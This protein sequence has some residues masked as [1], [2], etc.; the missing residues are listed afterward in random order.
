MKILNYGSLNIDHVYQM[1]AFVKAGETLSA[2]DCQLHTGGKGLNQSVALARAGA[3]VFHGGK[4]GADGIELKE[5]LEKAGAD[6]SFL[7]IDPDVPTGH[8][9]IQVVPSGENCILIYG[10]TNKQITEDEI[11]ETLG[12]FE[13]GDLLLLQNEIS[14]VNY[15][16]HRAHEKGMLTVLNPSPITAGLL[17]FDGLSLLDWMIVNQGEAEALAG[18][19]GD[20]EPLD[21]IE[22]LQARYPNAS[23]V[24]TLGKRG[25]LCL[26]RGQ[27]YYSRTYDYGKRVDTTGAGDT[28]TG[29]FLAGLAKGA[30]LDKCMDMA[31]RA[32][33]LSITIAGAANSIPDLETV[34]TAEPIEL[35]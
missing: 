9:I 4:I 19:D 5:F 18:T 25:A 3:C 2:T 8:A 16:I 12:H 30:P 13:A 22:A 32:S 7:R 26:S 31:S 21:V 14:N 28:F 23:I 33:G 10:G 20:L 35:Q 1:P 11:D 27:K 6:C 17:E 34:L 24:M 29:Y 15:L